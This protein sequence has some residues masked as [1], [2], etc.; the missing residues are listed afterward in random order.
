MQA[1]L[2]LSVRRNSNC[3]YGKEVEDF[4]DKRTLFKLVSLAGFAL[5][6]IGT[7]LSGWAES[8]EQEAII[9]EK[10]NEA[11]AARENETEDEAGEP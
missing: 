8:K 3:L 11:L 1:I 7:L 10:V 5:G 4:M 6:G 9:K 2:F